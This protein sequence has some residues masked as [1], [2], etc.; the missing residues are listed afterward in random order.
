MTQDGAHSVHLRM[1]G[2]PITAGGLDLFQNGRRSAQIETATPVFLRDQ[3][4]EV[5]RLGERG[6]K[7]GRIGTLTVK[8][9]PIFAGELGAQCAHARAYV[10][11]LVLGW[12][13]FHKSPSL[14]PPGT[15]AP[16]SSLA[17]VLKTWMAGTSP[18]T[19]RS[20]RIPIEHVFRTLQRRKRG[21]HGCFKL[22]RNVLR[23]PSLGAVNCLD[24]P[25]LIEKVDLVIANGKDLPGDI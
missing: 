21:S 6:D 15:R 1:T 14:S 8:C 25:W 18:A 5:A 11:K 24:R 17:L 3:R 12:P 10:G 2:S 4:S 22:D 9:T 7:F 13:L 19:T 16:K 23:G 20:Y